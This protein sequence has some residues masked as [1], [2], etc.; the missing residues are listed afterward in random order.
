MSR[1]YPVADEAYLS[2][3]PSESYKVQVNELDRSIDSPVSIRKIN[4]LSVSN[5]SPGNNI[6]S[7]SMNSLASSMPSLLPRTSSNLRDANGIKTYR[8]SATRVSIGSLSE[9]NP[10]ASTDENEESKSDEAFEQ[11]LSSKGCVQLLINY[12]NEN[13]HT[14]ETPSLLR[15]FNSLT[16]EFLVRFSVNTESRLFATL[17]DHG[18]NGAKYGEDTLDT[19]LLYISL[20]SL[21]SNYN[22]E[23]SKYNIS[24]KGNLIK[25]FCPTLLLEN[26]VDISK[27]KSPLSATKLEFEGVCMLADISGFTKLAAKYSAEGSAGLDKL[28]ETTTFFLGQFV[29]QVY[30]YE[31]D[32]KHLTTMLSHQILYLSPLFPLCF[33]LFNYDFLLICY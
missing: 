25:S 27:S 23:I 2:S 10:N 4:A 11:I 6:N 29:E 20:L 26:L 33:I 1:I 22:Q 18:W 21:Y 17:K 31:G 16:R 13:P 5:G 7:S 24:N 28:H 14:S 8:N 12:L 15:K 3:R 9:N 32:G 30:S 19:S